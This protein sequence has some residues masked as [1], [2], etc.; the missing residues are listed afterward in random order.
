MPFGLTN[1]PSTFQTAMNDLFKPY[2]RIVFFD[3]ILIYSPNMQ[4]HQEHLRM[5]F[6]LLASNSFF[7]NAK[8]KKKN[9]FGR[10]Q[11]G[12]FGP[13]DFFKMCGC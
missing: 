6:Q 8:I 5:T 13:R 3:N 10:P 7:S 2:L 12:I 11:I 4:F 1:T 9:L